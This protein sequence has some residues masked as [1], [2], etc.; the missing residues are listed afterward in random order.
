[1]RG[2]LRLVAQD[3]TSTSFSRNTRACGCGHAGP[4][5]RLG[6]GRG[7][8]VWRAAARAPTAT[9]AG[10]R[11]MDAS[12]PPYALAPHWPYWPYALAVCTGTPLAVLAVCTGRMHWHPTGRTGRMHWPYALAPHWPFPFGCGDYMAVVCCHLAGPLHC[13]CLMTS[14]QLSICWTRVSWTWSSPA[15]PSRWVSQRSG[16]SRPYSTAPCRGLPR[17]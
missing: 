5:G 8:G 12:K 16:A 2:K 4:G 17:A 14:R 6:K 11:G 3:C 7:Q 13:S 9:W 1:M 15:P 10:C